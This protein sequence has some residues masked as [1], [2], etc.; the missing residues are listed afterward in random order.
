MS[1]TEDLLIVALSG[2]ALAQSA[3]RANR[4]PYV[5]D[6]FADIDT[7]AVSRRC[8]RVATKDG[9]FVIDDL[10]EKVEFFCAM[11]RHCGLVYGAGFEAVPDALDQLAGHYHY[12][13]NSPRVMREVN[14]PE[15]FFGLLDDLDIP[16]PEIRFDPPEL[17]SGWLVKKSGATGGGHVHPY[18][19]ELVS[20]GKHYCQRFISGPVMSALFLA[21]GKTAVVLGFNTQWTAKRDVTS[22]FRYGGAMNRAELGIKQ[23]SILTRHILRLVQQLGLRGLNSLDF[24]VDENEPLVLELNPR[25]SATFELYDYDFKRGL[26]QAHMQACQG[27]LVASS[28]TVQH[29]QIRAHAIVY[30]LQ[31]L[32]IP[33]NIAWPSWS[34]D[35]PRGGIII[36]PGE[37]VCSVF[38]HGERPERVKHLLQVRQAQ[39][40]A[41]LSPTGIAA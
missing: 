14:D 23:C 33:K 41:M 21:T 9:C 38:A 13:G 19:H 29:F 22:P 17:G 4:K 34:S 8:V 24:I 36:Q 32:R 7:C 6:V 40:N 30:A 5:I 11:T 18:H 16:H 2:R 25:P 35:R 31:L 10:M 26:V 39:I 27:Y 1:K 28:N 15:N 20:D 12:Y 3:C 37:P